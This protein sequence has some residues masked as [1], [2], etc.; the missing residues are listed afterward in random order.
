MVVVD[1]PGGLGAEEF[2]AL[3]KDAFAVVG[4][5]ARAGDQGL[6]DLGRPGAAGAD[7]VEVGAVG[8]VAGEEDRFGRRG[9]GAD[10]VG[11][12]DRFGDGRGSGG[13]EGPGEGGG[14]GG[15]AAPDGDLVDRADEADRLDMAAG[16]LAG[17]ED[18]EA[19]RVR[20]GEGVGGGGAISLSVPVRFS[21]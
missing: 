11:F 15:V 13:V 10:D 19:V 17:A 5:E 2:G 12:G 1:Q 18:G 9:C 21:R 3:G 8:D 4:D 6:V 20:A 7:Q 14:F 16:L